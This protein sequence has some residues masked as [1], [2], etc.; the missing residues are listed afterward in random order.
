MT[1][2]V[3]DGYEK[4]ELPTN[5][6]IE[7]KREAETKYDSE[8]TGTYDELAGYQAYLLSQIKKQRYE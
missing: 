8:G 3:T 4:K 1:L 2:R 6:Y 5:V 7:K